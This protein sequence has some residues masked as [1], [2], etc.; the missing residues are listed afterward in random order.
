VVVVATNLRSRIVSG[1]TMPD[2]NQAPTIILGGVEAAKGT[3][4]WR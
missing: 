3:N 1:R 4:G 2:G